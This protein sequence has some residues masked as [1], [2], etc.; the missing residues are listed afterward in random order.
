M[1]TLETLRLLSGTL[2]DL[3]VKGYNL[4]I[5]LQ[6]IGVQDAINILTVCLGMS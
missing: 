2:R 1:S 3:Q 4:K 5:L 6:Q